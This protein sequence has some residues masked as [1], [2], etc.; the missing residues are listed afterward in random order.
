MKNQDLTLSIKKVKNYFILNLSGKLVSKHVDIF[1][2]SFLIDNRTLIWAFFKMILFSV[3]YTSLKSQ[4][5]TH[6]HGKKI[7]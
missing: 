2:S 3:Q 6:E 7:E 1:T 5:H 4:M